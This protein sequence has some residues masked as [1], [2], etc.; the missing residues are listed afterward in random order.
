MPPAAQQVVNDGIEKVTTSRL[1][2]ATIAGA[3]EHLEFTLDPIASSLQGSA[4]DAVA[5]G[6][7]DPV[8]LA[9]PG[10]YDLTLLNEVLAERGDAEVSGTVTSPIIARAA[11]TRRSARGATSSTALRDVDLE[12]G[13]GEFVCLIGASG[14]GKSTIL[15]LVAGLDTPTSGTVDVAG[16]TALMFQESAL[17]PWLTVA[18]NVELPMRLAGV[19]KAERRARVE[20]LLSAVHLDGFARQAAAPA[21]RRHAPARRPGAGVRP[22]RRH[23]ADGRAVRRARRDD[24]RRPAQRARRRSSGRAA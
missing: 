15:N 5:V 10:I 7:L 20:Q 3:W 21:V 16:R 9:D 22:G 24:P 8:D 4:D 17:F 19:P 6:L 14:C 11:C 23:P 12:V 2:D 18:A 1:A 13:D